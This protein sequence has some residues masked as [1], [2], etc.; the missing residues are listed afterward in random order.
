MPQEILLLVTYSEILSMQATMVCGENFVT[1]TE[2]HAIK[3]ALI[4]AGIEKPCS[5]TGS[6]ML[7]GIFVAAILLPPF[8]LNRYSSL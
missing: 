4:E 5:A 3:A 1:P 2:S 7:F 6:M 8:V